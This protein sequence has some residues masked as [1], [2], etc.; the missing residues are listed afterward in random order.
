MSNMKVYRT[1][2][3][4]LA[5]AIVACAAFVYAG[6]FMLSG[7]PHLGWAVILV[8]GAVAFIA[9]VGV[10]TGGS[11]LRLGRKGFEI[12]SPFKCTRFYWDEI[13]P[14]EIVKI[15][16]TRVIAVSYFLGTGKQSVSRA[17]TGMD[18][19]IGNTYNGSLQELC[20]TMNEWRSRYRDSDQ[21]RRT[22]SPRAST[23][24]GRPLASGVEPSNQSKPSRPFL[25]AFCA[26]LLVLVLNVL[27][28]LTLKLRGMPVTI[29]IAFAVGGLVGMWFLKYE[30]RAPTPQERSR[31][32]WAFSAL[33]VIP[34]LALFMLGSVGR[35]FNG[36]ALIILALHSLAYPAAAQVFLSEKRFNAVHAKRA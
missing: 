5:V 6:T 21:S 12:S 9:L 15:K 34:Y 13:E 31:F 32:L 28:R 33:I 14:L 27:L 29:G 36:A 3:R 30:N 10:F 2:R 1:S 11:S 24:D 25:L 16:K 8:F 20:E 35:A 19:A 7:R 4:K 26:A 22:V 17:T 18:L 23:A